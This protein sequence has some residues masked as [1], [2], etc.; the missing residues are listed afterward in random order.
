M[1]TIQI[2]QTDWLKIR[3]GCGILIYS[4]EQGLKKMEY[5][6]SLK[7]KAI[8]HVQIWNHPVY[9]SKNFKFYLIYYIM[10][11]ITVYH[12]IF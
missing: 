4:A 8:L 1:A 2:K 7:F 10:L 9:K 12:H 6:Y 3:S 5:M 11:F